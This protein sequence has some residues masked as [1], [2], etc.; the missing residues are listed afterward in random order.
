MTPE[1]PL[2]ELIAQTPFAHL[3]P[4][5][6]RSLAAL[7]RPRRLDKGGVVFLEGETAGSFFVVAE[8]RLKAFRRLPDG[9]EITVFL[10]KPRE[11]FGF[12]PLLDG[13][14][15]PLSVEALEP[16]TIQELDRTGFLSFIHQN[17]TFCTQLMAY[18][19]GRL[20]GCLDQ[21]SLVGQQGALDRTA[22][23]LLGLVERAAPDT[24]VVRAQLPFTQEEFART[25]HL[26]PE[27]LS[28][29]LARL[30]R[31]GLIEREG[32]GRFRL[33]NVEELRRIAGE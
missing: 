10:I 13:G 26:A 33:L 7:F 4:E 29:A 3:G 22:R 17:P 32:R 28:R 15:R 11:F 12:L 31:D 25:L 24:G 20:R 18:L 19:A 30:R 23:G 27:N 5:G 14:P 9:R 21:L 2:L 8:G 1:V 16:S 6:S